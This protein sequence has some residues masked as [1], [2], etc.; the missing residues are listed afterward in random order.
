M[1]LLPKIVTAVRVGFV[2]RGQ[3]V[4]RAAKLAV[5]VSYSWSRCAG[6]PLI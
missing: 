6:S 1:D 5:T 4:E 3:T 2:A